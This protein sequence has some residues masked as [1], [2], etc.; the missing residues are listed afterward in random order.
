[1]A[2]SYAGFACFLTW[3]SNTFA[4]PPA[5]RAVALAFINAFSQLANIGG[6]WVSHVILGHRGWLTSVSSPVQICVAKIMG[7]FVF[8]LLRDLHFDECALHRDVHRFQTG[9]FRRE[10]ASGATRDLVGQIERLGTQIP[11]VGSICQS[12]TVMRKYSESKHK[13]GD[14]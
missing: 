2:Q 14:G 9:A 13:A 11:S 4:R 8:P 5:K 1:M 10:Q 6:S 3:S 12:V 7:S